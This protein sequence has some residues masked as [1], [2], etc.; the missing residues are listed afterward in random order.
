[1][2]KEKITETAALK[3]RLCETADHEILAEM[4][5]FV[6]DRLM[7][8]DV[9]QLCGAAAHERSTGRLNHRNGYRPCRW[10]IR[11]GAV[12]VQIPKRRKGT[13]FP[14]VLEPRRALE[15]AMTARAIVS[16]TDGVPMA[17][18]GKPTVRACQRCR[19]ATV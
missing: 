14:E 17:R 3:A 18:S 9:D 4:Q 6:A 5:G 13:S 1:M 10:K 8:L 15:K 2:T 16:R 12:D 11:A 19:S 7:A